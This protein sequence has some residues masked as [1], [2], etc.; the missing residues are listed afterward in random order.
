MF[1]RLPF[2]RKLALVVGSLFVVYVLLGW[3]A[4]PRILQSQAEQ[5]IAEKTGH[6][7]SLDRPEFNPLTLSLRLSNLRLQE[8]DGKPLFAFRELNVDLSATSLFRHAFIFDA[9][10]LDA[11]EATVVLQR[12]GRLN[13]SALIEALEGK[14]EKRDSALPR[15]SI[16]SFI[17]TG[18]QLD[19]ADNK[20]S[21]TT[22]VSPLDLEL[23]DISTLPNDKDRYKISARTAFGARVLWQGQITLNP[24]S[25]VGS[26][27]I[28]NLDLAPLAPYFKSVLPMPPP[29]GVASL[30]T[31]YNIIYAGGRFDLSLGNTAVQLAGF[32]LN[33]AG[34]SGPAPMIAINA[35][36]A[37]NGRF[38]LSEQKLVLGTLTLSGSQID[39]PQ[40]AGAPAQLLRLRTLTLEDTQV[41]MAERRVTV[42]RIAL[43][44]GLLR[45]V[46][47]ANGHIDVLDAFRAAI[48][49]ATSARPAA[50]TAASLWH[51]GIN[52]LELD[53][54]SATLRDEGE[55]PAADLVLDDIALRVEGI[56]DNLSMPVPVRASLHAR[57]GGQL[58]VS[59]QIIPAEPSAD[60][61]LKLV[62]LALKPAQPYIAS[63]A[64]LRLTNGQLNMEGRATYGKRGSRYTGNF[65]VRNL[66]LVEAG[67]NEVFL[68]WKFLGSR[69]V[70]VTPTKLDI[71]RLDIGG[72]DTK[73]VINKDKSININEILR[74]PAPITVSSPAAPAPATPA[75]HEKKTASFLVNIDRVKITE[76]AMDFADYSLI[77]PFETHIHNLHGFIN[78][79][80]SLPATFGQIELDGQIDDYGIARAIGQIELFNPT[81]FTDVKVTFNNVEMTRLTPYSTTFAGRRIDSGKLLLNLEYKINKH[82]LQGDNEI[83]I[84]RL[85]LGEHVKSPDAMDLPLDLAIAIL[86]DADGRIDLGLPVHGSLDDPQF[87]YGAI[88]WKAILNIFKMIATAPFRAL[89]SLFGGGAKIEN[90]YFDAGVAN[91]SPPAR[92][93]IVQLAGTLNKRPRLAVTVHGTYSDADRVAL[94]DL[95]LR[96]AVAAEAGLHVEGH[97]DPGP[98]STSSPKVQDALESLFSSRI[99][100][101]ELAAMK[102][103]FR[104]ANPG[105]MEE[106]VTGK[107]MSRLSG[108][109]RETRTLNEHEVDQLK[110]ADFFAVL[111][112]RLRERETVSDAQLESLGKT[113]GENTYQ[114]LKAAGAPADRLMLGAAEK[115]ESDPQGV[116]LK[117]DL[118]TAPKPTAPATPTTS[119][120][121]ESLPRQL[122]GTT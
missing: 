76:G 45:A 50:K 8:P 27:G 6:R 37:R 47:K 97:E 83:V 3:L 75:T 36:D 77:L 17:L 18:G 91:L 7:L 23:S 39:L 86:E 43:D 89:A 95:Q 105:Q 9:I 78:S 92:E 63:A 68:A 67:T 65:A 73:L 101:A 55:A 110:G 1:V 4:L 96:R 113:R 44:D 80:S 11:P 58:D 56:S 38:N 72:L 115:G 61:H 34:S 53:G 118:G 5:Y 26:L 102:E 74:K 112:Q 106:G 79:V 35:I 49:P 25:I 52:K 84:N 57:D 2:P 85:T 98:I 122:D 22:R 40:P 94:Q 62:G 29:L 116:P 31:D 14:E 12:D 54:F 10:R 99:G 28:E 120:S 71:G 109:F 19:F 93:N 104:K 69:H 88:V 13:W 33:S 15:L 48:P 46:R 117:F 87:S 100:S 32:R 90:V 20:T 108:L 16:Q 42:D 107:I 64:K 70:A 119:H 60:L 111:F 24:L 66:R 21:F 114:S 82:Q 41:N 59:G 51:Y 103:G 30:S 121:S 81:D